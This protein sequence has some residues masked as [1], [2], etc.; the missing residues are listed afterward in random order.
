MRLLEQLAQ[1][2]H[3]RKKLD[4]VVSY[5]TTKGKERELE[6]EY[7]T[8]FCTLDLGSA[9]VPIRDLKDWLRKTCRAEVNT[10]V[11]K[12]AEAQPQN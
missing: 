11:I 8:F 2:M 9:I 6:A 4:M 10:I 3:E 7:D 12:M 1:E 5:K